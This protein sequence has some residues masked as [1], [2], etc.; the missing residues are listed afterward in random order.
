MY[1]HRHSVPMLIG[2]S[3][4][5][6]PKFPPSSAVAAPSSH[7]L[8][9]CLGLLDT[10]VASLGDQAVKWCS[11]DSWLFFRIV[12]CNSYLCRNGANQPESSNDLFNFSGWLCC[13]EHGNRKQEQ[14]TLVLV[15]LCSVTVY[16]GWCMASSNPQDLPVWSM[17]SRVLLVW[18]H[19]HSIGKSIPRE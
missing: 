6:D 15:G 19:W 12:I 9:P 7:Y 18:L 14:V 1:L 13:V 8:H 3:W 11:R 4:Q 17:L 2:I 16:L 10:R 5:V